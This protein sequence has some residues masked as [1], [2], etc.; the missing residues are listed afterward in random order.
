M[1]RTA[2]RTLQTALGLLFA[3]LLAV[4]SCAREEA[5][6]VPPENLL[7][8]SVD[9]LRADHLGAY[10]YTRDTSPHIDA[11]AR[12]GTL[13]EQAMSTSSW[14]L[15]AHASLLTGLYPSQHR[16]ADDGVTLGT[17][18]PTLAER[19]RDAGL[20]TFAVIAHIYVA[21][22]FGFDRGFDVFDD[23]LIEDG[24]TNPRGDAVVSR[25]LAHLDARPPGP[26]FGFIHFYDPHWD[27][28]A[29]APFG[30]RFADK[31]YTGPMDGSFTAMKP[32]LRAQ[33]SIP[34]A[35]LR[36]L[37][38]AYDGEIAWL[39]AQLGQLF[40]ALEERGLDDRTT[41]VLTADHGE[42][43]KEHARLGHGNTLFEEQL[44]V[45]LIV[46]G[47]PAL[48]R[49][50]RAEPV[51]LVD[52]A[53][54]LLALFGAS[55][56]ERAPG[57]S[58]A[59]GDAAEERVLFAETIRYGLDLLAGRLGPHKRIEIRSAAS[60]RLF[61]LASD[62]SERT[63]LQQDPTGG[64]LTRALEEFSAQGDAGWQLKLIGRGATPLSVRAEISTSGR[65]LDARH[66]ASQLIAGSSADF[67]HF[68]VDA[69]RGVLAFEVVVTRHMGS[70][71]FETDP[72]DAPV[73]ITVHSLDGG[74][75][76]LSG[77]PQPVGAPLTLAPED[78]TLT[79]PLAPLSQLA[80]GVHILARKAKE[81]LP[82][83]PGLPE[84]AQ[85]RLEALGY[86]EPAAEP[87]TGSG[88]RN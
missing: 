79:L 14:T 50:R 71:R 70:I 65:I 64:R 18:I 43:F 23:S 75:L 13:F 20:Y 58:L 66:Y 57:I 29:P 48:A 85:R 31:G 78:P 82:L 34:P 38:D 19:L 1:H 8:I 61:D 72:P 52:I 54:T 77:E 68:T 67:E 83:A 21:S 17:E 59:S 9:T 25:F 27:Y 36:A 60:H 6:G 41:I 53:P 45:P 40:A 15:P 35:D 2:V 37:V 62:P 4:S 22:P 51:S 76:F 69:E 39:D 86:S 33:S 42:E 32:Y 74:E 3:A 7:L 11:L 5:P 63:P 55:P 26:F 56:L 10:G 47:H 88:E 12:K 28:S 24:A 73:D 81:P 84:A 44:R 87:P 80:N 30:E 46:A 49:G 16:V